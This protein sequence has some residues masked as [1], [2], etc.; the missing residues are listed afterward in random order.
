MFRTDVIIAQNATVEMR[1]R[2]ERKLGRAMLRATD[3][4]SRKMLDDVRSEMAAANLGSLGRAIGHFS[5]MKKGAL[6]VE[7]TG[8][9]SASG[10]IFNRT[11]SD[12]S[13]GALKSYLE[14]S[15]ILPVKGRWLWF[16]TDQIKRFVGSG[17][18]RRRMTPAGWNAAGLDKKIGPLFQIK[19]PR[20][21]PLL[22]LRN[23]G[24]SSSGARGSV[25]SLRRDGQPRK[26]QVAAETIVAFI[27]IPRTA[28]ERRVD[29]RAI[30]R[31]HAALVGRDIMTIMQGGG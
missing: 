8:G 21:Y 22:V 24:I 2:F 6:Y 13:T 30:A 1:R 3:R 4:R 7:P 31:Q 19:G 28:R 18:N 29:V 17:R 25:K 10:G 11:R 20:G 12:R 27:A 14:G 16:A 5:D 23:V 15:T 26:G 9:F